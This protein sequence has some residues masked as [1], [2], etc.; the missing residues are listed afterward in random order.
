VPHAEVL[1]LI[2][3]LAIGATVLALLLAVPMF[4]SM[5]IRRRAGRA[6]V[7]VDDLRRYPVSKPIA[8]AAT[9]ASFVPAAIFVGVAI[10]AARA[11]TTF[12]PTIWLFAIGFAA[13]G[14]AAIRRLSRW[15]VLL[16]A[17]RLVV[18]RHAGVRR[19][20]LCDVLAADCRHGRL[21]ILIRGGDA[22]VVPAIFSRSHR[23][24]RVLTQRA[25]ANVYGAPLDRSKQRDE[26][27]VDPQTS[28]GH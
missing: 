12:D 17:E 1:E 8:L 15:S 6:I 23:I 24:L 18:S 3:L 25:E 7:D 28:R 27:N 19:I 14:I 16:E 11:R 26:T 21:I 5:A 4:H 10:V 9:V 2:G 20:E 13:L 22:Y